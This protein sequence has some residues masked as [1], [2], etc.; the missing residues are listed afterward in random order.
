MADQLEM[1]QEETEVL[2]RRALA[3]LSASDFSQSPPE[4]AEKFY[5]VIRECSGVDDP[6]AAE[7]ADANQK[8][9]GRIDELRALIDTADDSFGAALKLSIVANAID[10][11]AEKRS[12]IEDVIKTIHSMVEPPLLPEK[13]DCFRDAVD[14]A[15]SI[16]FLTDNAG[17]IVLDR[18]LIEQMPMEK[19]TVAVR[20]R[21]VIND[22]TMADAKQVGLDDIVPV[23]SNG[24]GIPGTVVQRCSHEFQDAW[25]TADLVVA[26]GQG[27]F[28]TLVGNTDKVCY[29]LKVKCHVVADALELDIGEAYVGFASNPHF[30]A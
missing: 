16:L 18:L 20:G 19:I 1:D 29:L 9:M 10:F 6:Y 12:N 14:S 3:S 25:N 7:K 23:I 15:K 28:E 17:E 30:E 27:N 4:I 11:G 21:P 26:K 5:G 24:T 13:I 2:T 22:C 8:L